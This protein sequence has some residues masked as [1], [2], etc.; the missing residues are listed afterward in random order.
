MIADEAEV[1]AAKPGQA[2]SIICNQTPFYAESGGQIGVRGS[3]MKLAAQHRWPASLIH[4]KPRRGCCSQ[5]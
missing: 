3:F 2:V 4:G 5:G 1:E